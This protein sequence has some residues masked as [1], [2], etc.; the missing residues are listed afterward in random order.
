ML[1]LQPA[2]ITVQDI[3]NTILENTRILSE[4]TGTALLY[5]MEMKLMM[6]LKD[7][8]KDIF[9]YFG[10]GCRNVSKIYLPEGYDLT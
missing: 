5:L 10:L 6:N 4:K 3:L 9:S 7:L 8:G 1:L 2:A